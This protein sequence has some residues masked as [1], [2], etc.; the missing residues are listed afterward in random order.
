VSTSPRQASSAATTSRTRVGRGYRIG[1]GMVYPDI[2]DLISHLK[3][4]I[5]NLKSQI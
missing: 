2:L 5:S 4:Q 3:F 1:G